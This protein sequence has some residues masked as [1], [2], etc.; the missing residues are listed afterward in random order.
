M[1]SDRTASLKFLMKMGRK[2]E[3]SDEL[4]LDLPKLSIPEIKLKKDRKVSF[5]NNLLYNFYL[6]SKI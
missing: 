1:L 2:S 5:Q 6:F 3:K 4:I